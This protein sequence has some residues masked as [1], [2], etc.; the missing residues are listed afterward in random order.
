MGELISEL[1]DYS[2]YKVKNEIAGY[3][4]LC[5]PNDNMIGCQIYFGFNDK[6][7]DNVSDDDI[8]LMIRDVNDKIYKIDNNSVYI[9]PDL[10]MNYLNELTTINDTKDYMKFTSEIIHPIVYEIHEKLIKYE[11][12]EDNINN[13][14][15]IVTKNDVDRKIAGGLELCPKIG[16]F[17]K[18]ISYNQLE[19][20]IKKNDSLGEIPI[21]VINT[22][23]QDDNIT[24]NS[25]I[26][27]I[28]HEF[29]NVDN[30]KCNKN[31]LVRTRKPTDS[32]LGFSSFKFIIATLIFS[33][34]VGV[35]IGYLIIR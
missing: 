18:E 27:P 30:D 1:E 17:M 5:I 23:I 14:I 32:S 7:L 13:N 6:N 9:V 28:E 15:Q 34:V 22:D 29:D 21:E 25:K 24:F 12:N 35:S 33:L 2:I 4:Y 31:R 8:I 20:A 10:Q 11:M 3:Y 19:L 26:T 16:S